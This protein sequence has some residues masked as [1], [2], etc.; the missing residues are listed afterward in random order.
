M[1]V[2]LALRCKTVM[3]VKI[4]QY[5]DNQAGSQPAATLPATEV[6]THFMNRVDSTPLPSS[7]AAKP[8]Q[9]VPGALFA[10]NILQLMTPVRSMTPTR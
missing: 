1:A 4:N 10:Q 3:A 6:A 7:P 8:D 2:T 5:Q 9:R